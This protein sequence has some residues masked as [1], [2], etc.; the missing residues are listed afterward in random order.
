MT[1]NVLVLMNLVLWEFCQKNY[2]TYGNLAPLQN[3]KPFGKTPKRKTDRE[4]MKVNRRALSFLLNGLYFYFI[5]LDCLQFDFTSL[6]SP[7][8]RWVTA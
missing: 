2:S 3:G 1:R 7:R 5:Y 4:T 8:L 6:S